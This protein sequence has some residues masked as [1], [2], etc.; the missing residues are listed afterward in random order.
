MKSKISCCNAG[1][2]RRSILRGAPL[3][4]LWL[5][6]GL[7]LLPFHLLSMETLAGFEGAAWILTTNQWVSSLLVFGYGLLVAWYQ[8]AWL[9]R[10]R[11]AYHYGSLPLRRETQFLTRYLSGLLFHVAPAAAVS[12]LALLVAALRGANCA[13][14]VG[15][16]FSSTTLTYLFYYSLAVL[17]AQMVGHTAALP[18]L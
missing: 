7:I 3:W 17:L 15:A 6:G 14:A 11:S 16:L 8:F 5:L 13:A 10:T 2:L 4:G 12:L 9:Y 18:V 1:L